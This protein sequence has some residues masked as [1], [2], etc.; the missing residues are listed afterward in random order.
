MFRSRAVPSRSRSPPSGHPRRRGS[1]A[2]VIPLHPTPALPSPIRMFVTT[3]FL[4]SRRARFSASSRRS[5]F[6]VSPRRAGSG[7]ASGT[8]RSPWGT[9]GALVDAPAELADG[10]RI[11]PDRRAVLRADLHRPIPEAFQ[12]ESGGPMA[13]GDA[14]DVLARRVPEDRFLLCCLRHAQVSYSR[15][16]SIDPLRYAQSV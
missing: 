3:I 9:R 13:G 10:D 11:D 5:G 14:D 4:V 8:S 7:S 6:S 15:A 1:S 12:L 16:G 2:W